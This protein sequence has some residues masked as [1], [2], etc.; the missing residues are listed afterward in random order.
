LGFGRVPGPALVF[1]LEEG[2]DEALRMRCA[3]FARQGAARA[4]PANLELEFLDQAW[5]PA[6]ALSRGPLGAAVRDADAVAN[7]VGGLLRSA[8]PKPPG[9]ATLLLPE[10]WLRLVMVE[11]GA[12]PKNAAARDEV[13]RFRLRRLVP[14]RVEDLRVGAVAAAILP[15]QQEAYRMAVGFAGELVLTSFEAAFAAAGVRIGLVTVPSLG[16]FA[17]VR[18]L[19][20]V[21]GV[22]IGVVAGRDEY[23]L[24]VRRDEELVLHRHRTFPAEL[25]TDARE[26]LARRELGLVGAMFEGELAGE[27]LGRV[28]LY[29]DAAAVADWSAWLGDIFGR[30]PQVLGRE[31]LPLAAGSTAASVGLLHDAL[32]LAGAACLEVA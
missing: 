11:S 24:W 14:Y 13:L 12:L 22:E 10:A 25:P 31:H 17:G 32:P 23:A 8:G 9:E 16:L 20:R 6:A 19:H 7:A 30:P 4:T 27:S 29:A 15:G 18:A 5:I 21:P 3:R 28:L 26:T 1:S 2:A